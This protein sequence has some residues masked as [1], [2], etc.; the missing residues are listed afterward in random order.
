MTGFNTIIYASLERP[1]I[2]SE[3][4]CDFDILWR[5]RQDIYTAFD[6]RVQRYLVEGMINAIRDMELVCKWSGHV[7]QL[8]PHGAEFCRF[9]VDN[10][11][12]MPETN[13]WRQYSDEL[14]KRAFE[15]M[16]KGKKKD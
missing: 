7:T 12:E 6:C 15:K 5:P 10:L 3:N 9:D 1:R 4:S 2:N 14:G 13:P 8:V 11:D 16:E